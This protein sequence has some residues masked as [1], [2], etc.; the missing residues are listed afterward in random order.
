MR[1]AAIA[2]VAIFMTSTVAHGEDIVLRGMG[3]FHVGGHL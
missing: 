2:A 3:S 1:L